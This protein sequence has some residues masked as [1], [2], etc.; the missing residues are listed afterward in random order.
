MSLA[1]E[2]ESFVGAMWRHGADCPLCK[3]EKAE[4][5]RLAAEFESLVM[6]RGVARMPEN[7][8]GLRR[9]AKIA[10]GSHD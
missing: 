9:A 8:P 3:V 4:A 7:I 6:V 2:H 1:Y 10:R 5:L